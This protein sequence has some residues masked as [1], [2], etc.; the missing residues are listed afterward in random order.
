MAGPATAEDALGWFLAERATLPAALTLAA[1]AGYATHSRQLAWALTI[2]LLQRGLWSALPDDEH[3]VVARDQ[4]ADHW[5]PGQFPGHEQPAGSL[6][7][8][9]QQQVLL[10]D[11]AGVGVR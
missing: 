2:F 11:G 9:Q 8:G 1:E 3:G 6:R 10:A 5:C 4:F 7:V